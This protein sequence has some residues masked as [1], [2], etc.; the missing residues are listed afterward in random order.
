M[1]TI[2]SLA[3]LLTVAS[4]KLT[5]RTKSQAIQ[6]AP[7]S[8]DK[9]RCPP[10]WRPKMDHHTLTGVTGEDCCDK[11]CEL[12]ECK[13][14]YRSN[15]AYWGNVGS[16]P[17][18]CCDKMCGNEFECDVG[19]VLA[20]ATAPGTS[21]KDCCQP[22]CELFN[23][24]APWA[25]SAAKKDVVASSAEECCD[26][27]CA[28][29]DCSISGWEVNE[30]KALQAGSTP[31]DCCTPLCGN[32]E[33][34]TCPFGWA[35]PEEDVN[36]TSNGTMEG[37]CQT[38]CKAFTCS[39]GFAPNVSKEDAFGA[40][41]EECCLPTCQQ[42]NCSLED[43]WA[44]WPAVENDIGA[45]ASQCCLPTCKQWTCNATESWLPYPG[46]SKDNVTGA[47]NSV[48]CLPACHTYSCSPA[49]GLIQVPESEKVGGTTDEEC[50]ESAKCTK[51]RQN[52]TELG[53]KEYCNGL[54]KEKCLTMYSKLLG[55][56]RHTGSTP[57]KN[58][59]GKLVTTVNTS[60]I[61]MCSF[62]DV[63]NLCRYDVA[64]AIQGGCTGV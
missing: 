41:D 14:V 2:A 47:S 39:P 32:S 27:T 53:E 12:F 42:F 57:V 60:S 59:E 51:V 9:M 61:V 49:K 38:Q 19:Y 34:V 8:C 24:T 45:N 23:C 36:K 1:K 10:A 29:V 43:G 33:Q 55:R 64:D 30:S 3:V 58:A 63:Y 62:D 16:S 46:G 44:P 50:C 15:E 20:D 11:T 54:E 28:A 26:K 21:K 37:C 18:V 25:P 56:A 4:K 22:K 35:V 13:G 40:S 48:C 52:M 6:A 7:Q 31:E 5:I 17:Q